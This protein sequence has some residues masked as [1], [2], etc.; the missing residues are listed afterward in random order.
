MSDTDDLDA[1]REIFTADAGIWHNTDN[2]TIGVEQ[3]IRSI[4]GIKNASDEYRYTEVKRLPTPEGFVQQHV[5]IIRLKN[6]TVITDPACCVC[7]V[8]GERISQMDAY[9][10]SAV[11]KVPGF[12]RN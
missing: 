9:H 8:E 5:L 7:K 1:M 10:D 12:G 4:R 3:S 2:K 11:F 6:G